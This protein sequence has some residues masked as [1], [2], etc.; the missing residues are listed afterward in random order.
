MTDLTK[1]LQAYFGTTRA[2]TPSMYSTIAELVGAAPKKSLK[3]KTLGRVLGS[4]TAGRLSFAGSQYEP[5]GSAGE[6]L[7]RLSDQ[8]AVQKAKKDYLLS[9]VRV[10]GNINE[11]FMYK[12]VGTLPRRGGR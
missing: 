5:G 9:N 4:T 2:P 12:K 8:S 10:P 6:N 7:Y 3:A 11:P 1:E